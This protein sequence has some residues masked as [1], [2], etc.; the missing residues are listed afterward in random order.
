MIAHTATSVR[1]LGV[2]EGLREKLTG[3]SD[4][5][6][7]IQV[8]DLVGSDAPTPREFARQIDPHLPTVVLSTLRLTLNDIWGTLEEKLWAITPQAVILRLAP[9][10]LS[11]PLLWAWAAPTGA[12]MTAFAPE[13]PA[14]INTLDLA[15]AIG[16]L[17]E[18]DLATRAGQ[19]FDVTGPHRVPMAHLCEVMSITLEVPVKLI[20]SSVE[21]FI[22]VM[23][24]NG[25]PTGTAEWIA[26]YQATTS[27][28][29]LT[30][31]DVLA[32]LL[33]RKPHPAQL[34]P[35]AYQICSQ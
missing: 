10:D 7:Q 16:R 20:T 15:E 3:S 24:S 22:G 32:A 2:R 25:L 14:W 35:Q 8:I 18:D 17:S 9:L 31:T 11:I 5:A 4:N 19:A 27:S 30:D 21:D 34:V 6:S 23:M 26:N 1:Y 12:L 28:P 29:G 33:G 13:G